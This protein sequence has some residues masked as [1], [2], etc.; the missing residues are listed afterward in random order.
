MKHVRKYSILLLVAVLWIPLVVTPVLVGCKSLKPVPVA[1]GHDPV[2]V[3]AERAQTSSLGIYKELIEWELANRASLPAEVSRAVD[4]ARAEFPP[5]W[6]QSRTALAFYK[7]QVPGA[8][9]SML[10]RITGALLVAQ[11]TFTRLR[12]SGSVG[13]VAQLQNAVGTLVSSLKLLFG[14]RSSV[15]LPSP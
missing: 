4:K 7:Q 1:E 10:D 11:D 9:A 8:D 6:E 5:A 3:F 14:G 12:K 13:E 2:V 15:P